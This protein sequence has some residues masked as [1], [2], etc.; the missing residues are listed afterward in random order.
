[1]K[2][3]CVYDCTII[4]LDKH[5]H[6]KGN[7]TVVENSLTIPFEIHRT[8]YLYDIPGGESRGGHAHKELRQLIVATSGSF[9]V[10]L[11]DGKV[12]RTF[13]L[14]RPYQGLLVVPGIWRTLDDFSSGAVCLVLASHVYDEGDYIRKYQD[15][16]EYKND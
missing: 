6:E 1:M 14:N 3:T 13:V 12:K 16:I 7:I 9:T 15:F 8:Y 10:T 11:D 2:D 5:H 4:E